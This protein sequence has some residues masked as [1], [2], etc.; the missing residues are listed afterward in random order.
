M[1]LFHFGFAVHVLPEA[2]GQFFHSGPSDTDLFFVMSGF[3][4]AHLSGGQLLDAAG[5]RRFVW[6]RV[7]RILPANLL[8]LALFFVVN[9]GKLPA[10]SGLGDV[11]L[12]V[13]ML[14]T[15]IVG[16]SHILNLTA[17][18]LSCLLFFYLLFPLVLPR[19]QRLRSRPLALLLLALWLLGAFVLPQ[20]QRW[21]GSFDAS[22]WTLWL[23]NSPALRWPEFV[24]GMGTAVL[25]PRLGTPP[26]WLI[27]VVVPLTLALL[28][29]G[30]G[31]RFSINNGIYAPLSL[32]LV[33]SFVQPGRWITRVGALPL[34]RQLASATLCMYLFQLLFIS[35]VSRC[36]LT[37]LHL[38]WNGWTLL[39]YVVL[40]LGASLAVDRWLCR[41]ATR[42]LLR[43]GG[44]RR[45][46][47]QAASAPPLL[48]PVALPA[49]AGD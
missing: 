2:V 7:A 13:S 9:R 43:L 35:V 31:E 27:A 4:L 33:V 26:R 38:S 17:W 18:S 19:L 5:Q 32:L 36:L 1:V 44:P 21:P 25:L 45:G 34:V 41:P 16:K 48:Q 40:L 15:W 14:Q 11:L 47:S 37:P 22:V 6:R 10:F 24:L 42:W 39:L 30:M 29:W 20:L 3:L 12:S 49:A 46:V 23:H 8:G 28:W